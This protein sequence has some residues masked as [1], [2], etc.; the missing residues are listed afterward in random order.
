MKNKETL[1]SKSNYD[2]QLEELLDKK[3]FDDE[4][5]SLILN[6]LYKIEEAYKDYAKVKFDTKLKW[7]I[8]EDL[9]NIINNTRRRL[10]KI[11]E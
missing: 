6:I 2:F 10:S 11:E 4:A 1:F 9:L 3:D 8:I 7:K 5:K